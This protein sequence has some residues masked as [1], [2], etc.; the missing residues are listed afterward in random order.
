MT[1][2]L[3]R[4]TRTLALPTA[5]PNVIP[6]IDV[7]L[8]LLIIFMVT[9]PIPTTDLRLDLPRPGPPAAV[10]IDP[11]IVHIRPASYGGSRIYVANE[12]TT[13]EHLGAT[14]L[15]HMLA[16]DPELTTAA[17]QAE[18]RVYVRADL[19]VAYQDVVTIVEALQDA[20]F[21]K[22]AVYAQNA[23]AT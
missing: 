18:G 3:A 11:T 7:L 2:A 9:A 6:F 5:D 8:V 16:A 17:A 10:N 20:G 12:E 15:A 1:A 21:Q 22:V 14:V 13:L 23:D 19:D 4:R